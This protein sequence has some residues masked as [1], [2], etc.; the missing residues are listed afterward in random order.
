[1]VPLAE[2]HLFLLWS[3]F[4]YSLQTVSK[5]TIGLLILKMFSPKWGLNWG[6]SD[7]EAYDIPT[8]HR[9][10]L[11]Y[12]KS[13]WHLLQTNNISSYQKEGKNLRK[14]FINVLWSFLWQVEKCHVYGIDSFFTKLVVYNPNCRNFEPMLKT[15]D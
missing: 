3:L 15:R 8:C 11:Y 10:S 6:P 4:F 1:M 9:A 5:L 13:K 2:T 14:H 12:S 7:P